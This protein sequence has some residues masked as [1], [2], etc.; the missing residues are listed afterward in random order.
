MPDTKIAS[1]LTPLAQKYGKYALPVAVAILVIF[2]GVGFWG[3][4]FSGR[5]EYFQEL[6]PMNLLLTNALLFAFHRHWSVAFILFAVL[7]S[8]VGYF[9][10][11]LGV[12]T[13][14]LFGDYAYGAA[15]GLKVWEVPLLIGLNWLM[16]VYTTGHISNFIRLPWLVKALLGA[17]LMVLLD[18][19]IEPV[20][21]QFDFWSWSGAD[22]PLSNFIGWFM[23]ATGLHVYF[24]KAPMYKEN[25]LAPYVFLVQ[26]LFFISIYSFL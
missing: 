14:L 13:G 16:L 3:F 26:L 19:F 1:V 18:I 11:V 23:I 9:S 22:I 10:E 20:A 2:H 24:Q 17:L 4:L 15:L 12:H 7:V 6:T 21:M 8:A 5:P 25:K